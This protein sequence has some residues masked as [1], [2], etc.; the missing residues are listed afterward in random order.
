MTSRASW[1]PWC[2]T[3]MPLV[4]RGRIAGSLPEADVD[5]ELVTEALLVP[6][7]APPALRTRG[8]RPISPKGIFGGGR[9]IVVDLLAHDDLVRLGF[10]LRGDNGLAIGAFH[11][12]RPPLAR[13]LTLKWLD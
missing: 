9:S 11:D 8:G 12:V 1:W 3:A 7:R 5:A 10:P 2:V 13:V 4:N 6:H